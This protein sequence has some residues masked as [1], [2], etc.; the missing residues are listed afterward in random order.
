MWSISAASEI[1]KPE[2]IICTHK[3]QDCLQDEDVNLTKEEC[4]EA[5]APPHSPGALLHD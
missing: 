5:E 1:T 3:V 4:G 2:C